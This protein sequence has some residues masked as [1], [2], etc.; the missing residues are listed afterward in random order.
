MKWKMRGGKSEIIIENQKKMKRENEKMQFIV[1]DV[2]KRKNNEI[3][4]GN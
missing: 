1:S 2:K 3:E 4:W